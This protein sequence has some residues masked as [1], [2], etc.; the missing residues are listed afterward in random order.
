M[1]Y[2]L[3]SLSL[4]LC[5]YNASALE[6]DEFNYLLDNLKQKNF[7]VVEA[8]LAEERATATTD[9]DYAHLLSAP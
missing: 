2:L 1:K 3:L 6:Q 7:D 5:S 9:P 4:C 8:Y